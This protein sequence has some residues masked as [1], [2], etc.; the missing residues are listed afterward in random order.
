MPRLLCVIDPMGRP[1][2]ARTYG[3]MP[4]PPFPTVALLSTVAGF[5]DNI[6]MALRRI[7]TP[8]VRVVFRRCAGGLLLILV[9]SDLADCEGHLNGLLRR[10]EDVAVLLAGR[11]ALDCAARGNGPAKQ[12]PLLRAM[13][14]A[15]P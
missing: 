7:G 8:D 6:G 5:A 15:G 13:C 2:L 3:G 9:A 11:A 12:K 1:L 10:C 4:A 14:P